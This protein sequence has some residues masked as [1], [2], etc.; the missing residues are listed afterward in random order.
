L[1]QNIKK[2]DSQIK[3]KQKTKRKTCS[4]K[5]PFSEKKEMAKSSRKK[6]SKKRAPKLNIEGREPRPSLPKMLKSLDV[7]NKA[8][9]NKVVK[10]LAPEIPKEDH[11]EIRKRI[12]RI[13]NK[14]NAEQKSSDEEKLTSPRARKRAISAYQRW[15]ES[16]H[17]KATLGPGLTIGDRSKKL[18]ALWK[19]VSKEE[20]S[21]WD[22]DADEV[23]G[24][25]SDAKLAKRA[26]KAAA[27][28]PKKAAAPEPKKAAASKTR[29]IDPEI[30]N[31]TISE[32]RQ[33]LKS[34]TTTSPK[35]LKT[36]SLENLQDRLQALIKGKK[37]T[38]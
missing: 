16:D 7:P 14:I 19:T 8:L 21:D 20:K 32:L 4:F 12:R 9:V 34:R 18:A 25:V 27:P 15:A 37:A 13:V 5:V 29:S 3:K 36:K 33:E 22:A 17:V 30:A 2:K 11:P 28:E 6:T 10:A 23:N 38:M 26:K 35:T 31:L 24:F 1:S